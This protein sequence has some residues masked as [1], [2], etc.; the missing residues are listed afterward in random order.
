GG[1]N[2]STL[3]VESVLY[4]HAAIMEAAVVGKKDDVWGEKPCAFIT[5]KEG[6]ELT[7]KEV[8]SFCRDNLAHYKAPKLVVFGSLPKTSTGKIQKFILRD[9]ANEL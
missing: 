2:I 8:I 4:R 6:E 9:K 3:E 5:L 7:E 1:E